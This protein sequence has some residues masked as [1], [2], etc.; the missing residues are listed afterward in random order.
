MRVTAWARPRIAAFTAMLNLAMRIERERHVGAQAYERSTGR[1]GYANSAARPAAWPYA[2][3]HLRESWHPQ[4]KKAV[5]LVSLP[6]SFR[7]AE[8]RTANGIM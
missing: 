6:L 4:S 8:I 2:L 5:R 7:A 3:R 1:D